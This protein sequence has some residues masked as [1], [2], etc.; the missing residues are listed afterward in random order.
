MRYLLLLAALPVLF[1][2]TFSPMQQTIRLYDGEKFARFMVE[3]SSGETIPVIFK[4]LTRKQN[5]DGSESNKETNEL[6]IFPPQMLLA[7][8]QKKAVR[9][10]YK[11][12]VKF[13][14]EK[15]YRVIAQQVPVNLDPS[16]KNAGIKML[17]KFQNALYV[18]DKKYKSD[19]KITQF[20]EKKNKLLVTVSNEG[21]KHQY[22]HDVKIFFV[23]DKKKVAVAQKDLEK[24]EGQNILAKSTRTFEFSMVKSLEKD[25][26]GHITF[27]ND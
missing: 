7:G 13:D 20:K 14:Q 15:S 23:K 25:F 5:R 6:S 4:I 24:L 9:V 22:L 18:E 21:A 10:S 17:L 26:V 27:A 12:P 2:F 11:G 19:L 16:D 8:G 1:S 3:N